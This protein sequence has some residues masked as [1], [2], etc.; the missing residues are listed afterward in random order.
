MNI[1]SDAIKRFVAANNYSKYYKYLSNLSFNELID[2]LNTL[3]SFLNNF[4]DFYYDAKDYSNRAIRNKDIDSVKLSLRGIKGFLNSGAYDLDSSI[5]SIND[6]DNDDAEN[7][8]EAI[9]NACDDFHND[10]DSSYLSLKKL[11]NKLERYIQNYNEGVPIPHCE[12]NRASLPRPGKVSS[13]IGFIAVPKASKPKEKV[14]KH[15]NLLQKIR[16][17]KGK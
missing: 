3:N 15:Y 12:E 8:K 14:D 1:N 4:D 9:I 10:D 11:E 5:P 13:T 16:S 6:L 7:I 17:K 2:E